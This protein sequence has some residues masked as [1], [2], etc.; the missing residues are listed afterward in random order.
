MLFRQEFCNSLVNKPLHGVNHKTSETKWHVVIQDMFDPFLNTRET[1]ALVQSL[2]RRL[3]DIDILNDF[4]SG[5]AMRGGSLLSSE[6]FKECCL[7][8]RALM[9]RF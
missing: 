7:G 9:N 8:Q 2:G 4:A 6:A 5:S 3:S 1:F